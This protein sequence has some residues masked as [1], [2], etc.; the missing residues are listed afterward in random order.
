MYKWRYGIILQILKKLTLRWGN[1]LERLKDRQVVNLGDQLFSYWLSQFML[2]SWETGFP[3]ILNIL[4]PLVYWGGGSMGQ[5]HFCPIQSLAFQIDRFLLKGYNPSAIWLVFATT[6][7]DQTRLVPQRGIGRTTSLTW[8]PLL[9]L[10]V[11]SW[12][13]FYLFLS[14]RVHFCNQWDRQEGDGNSFSAPKLKPFFL[15]LPSSASLSGFH[16]VVWWASDDLQGWARTAWM[17]RSALV[18]E[19]KPLHPPH[20]GPLSN[21]GICTACK[22]PLSLFNLA[23]HLFH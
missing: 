7:M 11:H 14:S 2:W 21:M 4:E 16:Q 22:A 6:Q 19:L 9:T 5:I 13:L 15:I 1:K 23:P 10:E 8:D 17:A 18:I 20:C 12:L 3:D